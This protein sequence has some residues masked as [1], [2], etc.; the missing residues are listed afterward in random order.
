M[1]R[2]TLLKTMLL[3]IVMMVGSVST[4]ADTYTHTITA[5]TWSTAYDTQILSTVSWA[6]AATGGAYWG[7]DAT[8]GQQFGSASSP[9]TALSL[10]TSGIAGTITSV[11]VT[12]AGASSF[13]GNVSVTVGG[14]AFLNSSATS[15]TLTSTST[16]YDFVG[17]ASGAIVIS[18]SQTSSKALYLKAIE[19]TYATVN[20]SPT[21]IVTPASLTG[22]NYNYGSVAPSAQQ[23]FKVGGT[24][25]TNDVNVAPVA[26]YEISLATGD[27]F[28]ATNP[29][30][31]TQ[32]A[33]VLTDTPIYVR[34][35]SGL[36]AGSYSESVTISSTGATS[37]TVACSGTVACVATGLAFSTASINKTVGNANFT[38]IATSTNV[39]TPIAYASSAPTV[40]TV[41]ATTGEVTILTAGTTNITASQAASEGNCAASIKY[42]LN[43]VAKDPTIAI[44]E[45]TVPDMAT[46]VGNSTTEILT[47]SGVNLTAGIALAVTGTNASL[48]K[49]SQATVDQTNG[50]A[51]TTDISIT[52]APTAVGTHTATLSITSAGAY[53]VKYNLTGVSSSISGL[54]SIYSQ[55]N[56]SIV[57]DKIVLSANE[58]ETIAIYNSIGQQLIL[59]KAVDGMNS[60][61]VPT[62]GVLIVKVANRVAKVIL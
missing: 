43:V 40:A 17:S 61:A 9:A 39:I 15:A 56:V 20:T 11:K 32:T 19:I 5:K 10:S 57:N 28:V 1:R 3:A 50:T 33:G 46:E 21:L 44:T 53:D 48:F 55:L 14:N 62:H 4:W 24:L 36:A 51:P 8:K 27:L 18:W 54:S 29:I 6:A 41:N 38:E 42:I 58:G 13:A 52:Y 60:I 23:S 35:K 7:Y 31:L 34:L 49:V 37:K 16:P 12:T 47:V 30:V 25:L 45:V 59:K 22:F 26:N 2:I